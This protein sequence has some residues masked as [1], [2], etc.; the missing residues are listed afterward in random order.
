MSSQG[1]ALDAGRL[2]SNPSRSCQDFK[3]INLYCAVKTLGKFES[4]D[5][6]A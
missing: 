1:F 6:E 4:S 5:A 2:R 3:N